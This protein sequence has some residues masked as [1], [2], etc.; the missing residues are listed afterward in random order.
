MIAEGDDGIGT[1]EAGGLVRRLAYG[2]SFEGKRAQEQVKKNLPTCTDLQLV[3]LKYS[4]DVWRKSASYF[5]PHLTDWEA[6]A[7]ILAPTWWAID[8]FLGNL[9]CICVIAVLQ[10]KEQRRKYTLDKVIALVDKEIQHR[11]TQKQSSKST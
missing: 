7:K 2:T 3:D 9:L 11:R 6:T 5:F 8:W 10:D 4:L 1:P